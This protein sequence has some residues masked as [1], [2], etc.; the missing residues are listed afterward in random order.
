MS[1][2]PAKS[3][4]PF[5]KPLVRNGLGCIEQKGHS[6]NLGFVTLLKYH[7]QSHILS[8]IID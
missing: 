8:N 6:K 5:K 7:I 3:T 2:G 1:T 4:G